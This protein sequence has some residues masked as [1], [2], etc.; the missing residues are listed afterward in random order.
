MLF[1]AGDFNAKIGKGIQGDT[2]IGQF[3]KGL[4]NSNGHTLIEL[5]EEKKLFVSN[6]AF[7]HPS[8][9]QTTWIG[10]IRDRTTGKI[11]NIFNQIDYILCQKRNKHLLTNAR[12]YAGTLLTSDHKLVKAS[13]KLE[14]HKLCRKEQH[15]KRTPKPNIAAIVNKEESQRRY[16]NTLDTKLSSITNDRKNNTDNSKA[17][18]DSVPDRLKCVQTI[19]K[20]SI[21]ESVGCVATARQN[22]HNDEELSQLS[23]RQKDIRVK[24]Q[25][26]K[27]NNKRDR[28]KIERNRILHT[29]RK[30]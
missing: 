11:I 6:S 20:Q 4:R 5:C 10:Q 26:T 7:D 2:C 25:N 23:K 19:I 17:R 27:D 28:L 3:S 24:I 1:I 13:F 30:R 22:K 8:R 21:E 29:I 9:H 12:S 15:S 18:A 14:K 16:Q